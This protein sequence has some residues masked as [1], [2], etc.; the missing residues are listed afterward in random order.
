MR[1]VLGFLLLALVTPP[2]VAG[3]EIARKDEM[4]PDGDVLEEWS[5]P[6]FDIREEK[7]C[8]DQFGNEDMCS[9]ICHYFRRYYA[10]VDGVTYTKTLMYCDRQ[11]LDPYAGT[12]ASLL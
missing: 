8:F 1:N 4:C 2:S 11:A 6:M 10:C 9:R 7:I 12:I 5:L 3:A